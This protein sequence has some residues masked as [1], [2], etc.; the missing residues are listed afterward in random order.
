MNLSRLFVVCG[1]IVFPLGGPTIHTLDMHA[2]RLRGGHVGN[3]SVGEYLWF[4]DHLRLTSGPDLK[5]KPGK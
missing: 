1:V 2:T 3:R 4:N 5:A